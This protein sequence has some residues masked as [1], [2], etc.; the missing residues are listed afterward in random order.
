MHGNFLSAACVVPFQNALWGHLH[1]AIFGSSTLVGALICGF[2]VYWIVFRLVLRKKISLIHHATLRRFEKPVLWVFLA[3]AAI[4]AVPAFHASAHIEDIV[5]HILHIFFIVC[6][7]WVAFACVYAV[8]D[9]LTRRYNVKVK[10]NLRARQ[11]QTQ[12]TVIRRLVLG[13]IVVLAAGVI[14]YTFNHTRLWQAGAGLLASAGLATLLLAAAAKST[15]SN[16]LAGIQIAFT[17]PIRLDDVVIVEGEWGRIEEITAAYVVVCIWN[18]QRLIVPLS[19]FIEHPFQNWTRTSANL[20]GTIFLYADYTCPIEPLR[21]ELTRVLKSTDLW[22]GKVN[23][24]QLTDVSEHTIQIRALMSAADSG[25]LFDLRCYAR[26]KMIIFLQT[27]YPEHLPKQRIA[28]LQNAP[29]EEIAI[30]AGNQRLEQS[31]RRNP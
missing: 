17:E 3:L 14:L 13:L 9:W 27:N 29:W 15:A 7:A 10:D 25:K 20:M 22:D 16:L 12:M 11:V 21:E 5:E 2:I 18:L 31:P 1:Q 24:L 23:V 4:S 8:Q 30:G 28:E 26:E 19:Y 6:L